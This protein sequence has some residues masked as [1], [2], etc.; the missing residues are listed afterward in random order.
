MK[1]LQFLGRKWYLT[2]IEINGLNIFKGGSLCIRLII[3]AAVFCKRIFKETPFSCISI[4]HGKSISCL[5][6]MSSNT[7]DWFL[8]NHSYLTFFIIFCYH[9][10]RKRWLNSMLKLE[11]NAFD[12]C[13][14]LIYVL[15]VIF[16]AD[17]SFDILLFHFL[18][19]DVKAPVS[20]PNK[21]VIT[22]FTPSQILDT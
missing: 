3:R 5:S 15:W 12:T 18:H 16:L 7:S 22:F 14:T 10:F 11:K 4:Q 13:I 6:N 17:T 19:F 9:Q 2:S 20:L 21:F 1:S 8:R